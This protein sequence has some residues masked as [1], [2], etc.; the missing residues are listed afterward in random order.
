MI[1]ALRQLLRRPIVRHPIARPM[2]VVAVFFVL[3]AVAL[4]AHHAAVYSFGLEASRPFFGNLAPLYARLHTAFELSRQSIPAAA[5]AWCVVAAMA[6]LA[7]RYARWPVWLLLPV[8]VGF[9]VTINALTASIDGAGAIER[10]FTRLR[11]EYFGDV[12]RVGDD[13]ARFLAD[14]AQRVE[15]RQLSLHGG[16]HPP[17]GALVLWAVSRMFDPSATTAAW[18]AIALSALAIVPAYFLWSAVS[19]AES[20]RAAVCLWLVTP[21]VVLFGATC[22]DG[23]FMLFPITAMA[24]YEH[25][26]KSQ[27]WWP[28]LA[29]LGGIA[30]AAGLMMTFAALVLGIIWATRFIVAC[31][32]DRSSIR[33]L[34]VVN[35]VVLAASMGAI[36]AVQWL[37][38]YDFIANVQASAK[39]DEQLMGTGAET[40]G[41]YIDVSTSNLAAFFIAAG[42]ANLALAT[43]A[44]TG[45]LRPMR[46]NI[47]L[48]SYWIALVAIAFS[49]LFTLEVERV[50][51]FLLP[52]FVLTAARGIMRLPSGRPRSIAVATAVL[53]LYAQ[54]FI[55]EKWF[56]TLW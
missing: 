22:M 7:L 40:A 12:R 43:A 13:P 47:R 32:A 46:F 29:C 16:T 53:A 17:G 33:R 44:A 5:G 51:L 6:A 18:A 54:T 11:L 48:V 10:P 34:V 30:L 50:W 37:S 9:A 28:V 15:A 39:Y 25:A 19:D 55:I 14:Y 49:T 36:G 3:W 31:V 4:W 23:V 35:L 1:G 27:R 41:R 56:N 26:T 20:A 45:S 52:L 42:L 38:G 24:L 2:T 21:S 8:A